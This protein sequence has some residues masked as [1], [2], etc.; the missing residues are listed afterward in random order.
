MEL[1]IET[2]DINM[3]KTFDATNLY[4]LRLKDLRFEL[5]LSN[6]LLS[7]LSRNITGNYEMFYQNQLGAH[8]PSNDSVP[9]MESF[10]LNLFL[11]RSTDV[12]FEIQCILVNFMKLYVFSNTTITFYY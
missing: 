3:S 8:Q 6:R 5:H 2:P 11:R 12:F 10:N 7:Y 4:D 1:N 9:L